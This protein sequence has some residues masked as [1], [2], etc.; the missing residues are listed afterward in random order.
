MDHAVLWNTSLVS[1]SI[2]KHL[3]LQRSEK[4]SAL[5][6]DL[7]LWLFVRW[8]RNLNDVLRHWLNWFHKFLRSQSKTL[9]VPAASLT[10]C[11]PAASQQEA[12][13]SMSH[14]CTEQDDTIKIQTE[15]ECCITMQS[16]QVCT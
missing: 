8:S 15:S 13:S 16:T 9:H 7:A 5:R 14:Q 6:R 3:S 1:C 2:L 11:L 10:G 12:D 4:S